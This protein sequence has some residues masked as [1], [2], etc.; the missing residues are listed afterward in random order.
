MNF[1]LYSNVTA[2]IT[3]YK[4]I[5]ILYDGMVIDGRDK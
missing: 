1:L 5:E 2:Y 4:F 3:T